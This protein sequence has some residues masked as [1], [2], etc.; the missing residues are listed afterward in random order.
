MNDRRPPDDEPR[1][2]DKTPRDEDDR[3]G[4]PRRRRRD[5]DED[6]EDWEDRPRRR[7]PSG[8]DPAMKFVVPLNTSPLAILA[9]YLG[10]VSV[11]C[12][13][14]PFA[15]LLGIVALQQLKKNPKRDGKGRAIFA[16]VMGSIFSVPLVIGLISFAAKEFK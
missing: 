13:P 12:I 2:W 16:I 6:E 10:L 4:R 1:P 14:A 7:R 11:L 8:P 5:E 9:G 15:L 3:D